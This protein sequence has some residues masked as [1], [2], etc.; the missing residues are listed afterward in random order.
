MALPLILL[1]GLSGAGK[2]TV[3]KVYEDLGYY[4]IDNLPPQLLRPLLEALRGDKEVLAHPTDSSGISIAACPGMVL[5]MDA[6]AFEL[7]G[8]FTSEI[9]QLKKQGYPLEIIF[10]E[11]SEEVLR[12][13]YNLT[14]R[15]HP[16]RRSRSL[17]EAIADER[18]LMANL[19]AMA[20][21]VVD[22]SSLTTQE[23]RSVIYQHL[24]SGSTAHM[25]VRMMSFGYKYGLPL[26]CDLVVD[27]RILANPWHVPALR[28]MTG[29]DEPVHEYIFRQPLASTFLKQVEDYLDFCLPLHFQGGRLQYTV[30]IGCTG[31]RHRSVAVAE[32]LVS[33]LTREHYQVSCVHRDL[34][35]DSTWAELRKQK[36]KLGTDQGLPARDEQGKRL[37]EQD[38]AME[39]QEKA[40]E[41]QEKEMEAQEE[42]DHG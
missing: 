9:R 37:G 25:G 33:Y 2:S 29:L 8:D 10:L 21:L 13:R 35:L 28:P 40:T 27:A 39:G 36:E 31:G 4:C 38:K 19:R 16:L 17:G 7:F 20:D 3:A 11:A 26:D 15:L 30:G 12:T 14:R 23:V 1:S 34:Y 41:R 6:R 32:A 22:T 18:T 42:A 5:V 24:P